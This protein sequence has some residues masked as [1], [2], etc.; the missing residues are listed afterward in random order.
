[1]DFTFAEASVRKTARLVHDLSRDLKLLQSVGHPA[2]E[3]M[4]EAPLV[5]DW[6]LGYRLEPAL[7]GTVVGHPLLADGPVTTSGIFYM[8]PSAGFA[9]TLSRYYRLGRRK[10]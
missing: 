3:S 1:M 8:D 5:E 6:V 10:S 4:I 9:R 2:V 7:I